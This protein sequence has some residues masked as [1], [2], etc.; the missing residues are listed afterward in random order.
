ML[1]AYGGPNVAQFNVGKDGI[2]V[3]GRNIA[4]ENLV[5][6]EA[7]QTTNYIRN[8]VIFTIGCLA[9]IIAMVAVVQAIEIELIAHPRLGFG[10]LLLA[11]SV[12]LGVVAGVI[13]LV[14]PKPWGVVIEYS[15]LGHQVL[16]N[17][18]DKA[19]AEATAS[20]INQVVGND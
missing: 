13:A 10:P 8:L 18:P 2:Q 4:L 20:Q 3:N 16:G 9:P 5:G 15:H 14:W 6:A 11:I 17:C 1:H 12:F 7:Y 19:A